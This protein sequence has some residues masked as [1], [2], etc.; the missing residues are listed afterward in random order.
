MSDHLAYRI[1]RYI[2]T[3]I[4]IIPYTGV[5]RFH[6]FIKRWYDS[7]L[8]SCHLIVGSDP[9]EGE[10]VNPREP[11]IAI[12]LHMYLRASFHRSGVNRIRAGPSRENAAHT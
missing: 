4:L 10:L 3:I 12:Y 2:K 6:A 7:R 1:A 9:L 11:G 8:F 5:L